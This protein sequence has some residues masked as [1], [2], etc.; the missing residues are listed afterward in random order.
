MKLA[1]DFEV[2]K[3]V[4]EIWT[5]RKPEIIKK[6][7]TPELPS[8]QA[9]RVIQFCAAFPVSSRRAWSVTTI[10]AATALSAW[11]EKTVSLDFKMGKLDRLS[12]VILRRH[13]EHAGNEVV[14]FWRV[15]IRICKDSVKGA[16]ACD[17]TPAESIG[18][19]GSAGKW[20]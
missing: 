3:F 5:M 2:P 13:R 11:S 8:A 9:T 19:K 17:W 7:D 14:W 4:H 12:G 18:G 10:Q 16:M 15:V 6:T 1:A 20:F